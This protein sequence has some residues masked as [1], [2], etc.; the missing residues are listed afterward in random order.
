M[1]KRETDLIDEIHE[2]RADLLTQCDNNL[3]KLGERLRRKESEHPYRIVN[4]M[5]YKKQ[6]EQNFSIIP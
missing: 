2:W 6:D 5:T 1:P 3:E 4:Q